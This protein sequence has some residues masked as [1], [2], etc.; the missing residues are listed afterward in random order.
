MGLINAEFIT[1]HYSVMSSSDPNSMPPP[2]S[3]AAELDNHVMPP[4]SESAT[5]VRPSLV[6]TD[7]PP[8]GAWGAHFHDNADG[9]PSHNWPDYYSDRGGNPPKKTV[10]KWTLLPE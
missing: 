10:N 2:E 3:V 5:P 7:G 1:N 4:S 8:N 9:V 6:T